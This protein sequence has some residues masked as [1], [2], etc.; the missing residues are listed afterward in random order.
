[1][2][3]VAEPVAGEHEQQH[4]TAPP[5]EHVEEEKARVGHAA[6]AGHERGEGAD[7]GRNRAIMIVL[8]RASRRRHGCG[9]GYSLLRKRLLLLVEYSWGRHNGRRS[10]SPVVAQDPPQ[11]SGLKS[12]SVDGG[13]RWPPME[14]TANRSE[15]PGRI[16]VTTQAG[17]AEDDDEENRVHTRG[18]SWRR[19]TWRCC[20]YAGRSRSR[21]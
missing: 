8:P 4:H 21:I 17:F 2:G 7:D 18:R 12:P 10:S 15:S 5:A 3:N 19:S 9:E 14:P 20:R 6:D 11:R 13:R 1:M 16:G